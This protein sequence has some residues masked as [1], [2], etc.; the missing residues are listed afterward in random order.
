M[1]FTPATEVW[2]IRS[3]QWTTVQ[4]SETAERFYGVLQRWIPFA[5]RQYGTWN[6]RPNCGHFF[7]GTFWYQADTAHT[8]AVLAIVAKLGDYNEAAAGVSK[9]SLNHMAV[10]AIRYMGFTHD[11]GP[12]DCVRA[13]GVLPYTSG[14]KWGGQGDNFFMASQNGRSVAAMAVAAWLL[15]DELDIETKLLVQNVTASYADRWCDDEPRNGVYYDT[16]CEEN[17][18]TS[19]GISAAMALF[20][21]HPHQEAWQRGFA[22][23][24]INSVTTYQDR[25]ADPSGL[26]DTPHG[27]LVKTVTFHPDF[28]SENHA[29]V[30]PSYFCAGTNL[31]AI[32]AV[33]AFMGQ[34]AVMPEAVHNNVPLYE[35]TVKVW[36]QFDGLA[37][38]VQGQ[39]WWY[40]RQHERQLTHTILNVLHG[41]AD[42]ARYAVEAL[43]M[44]EK[45]QLSNSKGALLEEN[46]EECVINREHAQFAKDLEHGSAYDIAV[47]YLLHAFG[48]PGTAPSEKSEMAERMAGVYV[49]PH[50]GSIV[51]RTSDTFTSF[52]WRNN[53]MALS[54]PQKS[55]WNVTPL[56][57]SF[58]G[59]VDMEGGSGRQGL[60][61]EHIVRYVEQ[62]RITPYEQGFGAVV[63]IPRGGG[64]L[65]Q[66]VAFVALPDGGSVYAER[67]RVTKACRLQN[68]RTGLIG[69]RN[70]RYE[71]LPE[72]AP[73]RRTLYTPDG[74]ET[75][76]GFYGRG[77][78]DRI[79]SFGRPAYINVDHEIGYLLFGSSG[80]RYVNRHVYPKWKGVEDI[81]VLNDRGEAL[82]DGPAVLEP[83]VIA[84]LP[85]RTAEQTKHASGNSCL[86]HTNER[87]AI[88][89]EKEDL[90]VYASYKETEM[91][92]AA[93]KRLSD[94]AIH[95]WE[96]ANR[97]TGSLQSW[98][99]N[100]TARSAGFLLARCTLDLR[101]GFAK[102][103]LTGACSNQA[104]ME[105]PD[106]V[107]LEC[108]AVGDRLILRNR[109]TLEWSVDI[110][111]AD[112]TKRNVML[113]A[114][115]QA[116]VCEL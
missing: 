85:N 53:V 18:W 57:A 46:G 95:L 94:S 90:L 19:A 55:V 32:H 60:T 49:Y 68:W 43:D 16:Q 79:H 73:G 14:K 54:L 83:T 75:F 103:G 22:A 4:N 10:S 100:V 36:A 42:A 20:P 86:W 30:H 29:F 112:G 59:T 70:E 50:G 80:V 67:F 77:E 89:L 15:W 110:T 82:F 62:E 35:R 88:V 108:I 115:G 74:E 37:V 34:T 24:A 69:I 40:N 92:I 33:F 28:T 47:S 7:G 105:L 116:V 48:G 81:L 21:D 65:M 23:W 93:E 51:H 96:G 39:D 104:S 102:L 58:T 66:D 64:E 44:I 12:E 63:T 113:P 26:I 25:L 111:V 38:P 61:N 56:Y 5:V 91:Q 52:T 27:N 107:E 2:R 99:G 98:S 11:T 97:L 101:P 9:E 76:E 87:N 78:P 3:L 31:R 8:A 72:L 109:G 6:G 84:A 41:N 1:Q 13:E 114:N 71:K 106:G 45:L 17:A